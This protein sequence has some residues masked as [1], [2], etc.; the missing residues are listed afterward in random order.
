MKKNLT[1]LRPLAVKLGKVSEDIS[2]ELS[3]RDLSTHMAV[4]GG[5][6]KGKSKLLELM[7]RQILDQGHG[8]CLIDPHG[9]LTEDIL[10]YVLQAK[11]ADAEEVR[12]RIHYLEPGSERNR[13]GFDPF[14]YTRRSDGVDDFANWL[15]AKVQSVARAI[16]RKQGEA[17][18]QGR[19]RLERF[20]S[21]VLHGVGIRLDE[22]G[23]HLSLADAEILLDKTHPRHNQ[24]F[25][26]VREQLKK[27]HSAVLS[28]FAKVHSSTPRQQED[29]IESTIGRLRSFLSPA[30]K[31]VFGGHTE[32]IDFRKVIEERGILLV[33]LRRTRTFTQDQ[34]N[35]IGGLIIN[36]ILEAAETA[37]RTN[38]IPF[39]LIIDEASRFVG[40]DLIDA[41]GQ[42]RKWN[43]SITLAVQDLS[44]LKN[45]DIDMAP[46]VLSQCGVHICFQQKNPEDLDTLSQLLGYPAIDFTPLVHEVDRHDG[47]DWVDTESTTSGTNRGRG[48]SDSHGEAQVRGT[49]SSNNSSDQW[50]DGERTG[51][52]ST[53]QSESKN[54]S[55]SD[56]SSR[57]ESSFEGESES[58]TYGMTPLARY[59]TEL[60]DEGRLR[61]GVDDQFHEIKHL[62]RTLG[63]GQAMGAVDGNAPFVMN[64]H[65]VETPFKTLD[66]QKRQAL[67]DGYKAFLSKHHPYCFPVDQELSEEQ[68]I[69]KLVV[70]SASPSPPKNPFL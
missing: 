40:Q 6:G 59:R 68:R 49:G 2:V 51:R 58:V 26:A 66:P 60:R 39:Y 36:E 61:K 23:R 25:P 24:V 57:S 1:T 70:A 34:G 13:F 53:G 33:N 18:F 38:R 41:F 47:Y 11:T 15:P 48:S 42:F 64:V 29:W 46:K 63:Q 10:A 12:R 62:L 3:T 31:S 4:Y 14:R 50:H 5:T 43:L 8:C 7:I 16:I 35:A 17:D 27:D 28:D 21:N 32:T 37:N 9:D 30:V 54:E 56:T 22:S 45:R 20:L 67:I 55:R 44:S 65:H 69:S 52:R 19:P